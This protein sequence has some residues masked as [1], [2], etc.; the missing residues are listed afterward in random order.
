MRESLVAGMH[1]WKE[2][3]GARVLCVCLFSCVVVVAAAADKSPEIWL[4]H[5]FSEIIAQRAG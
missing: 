4:S 2:M 5:S 3:N 1:E